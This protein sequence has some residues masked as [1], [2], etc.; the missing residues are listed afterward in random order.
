MGQQWSVLDALVV[1]IVLFFVVRGVRVGFVRQIASIAAL[2]FAFVVAGRFYGE[3]SSF[4]LPFISNP[5]IGFFLIYAALFIITFSAVILLGF[6]L[7]SIITIS[8]LGWFDRLLGGGLGLSKAILVSCLFFMGLTLFV[9]DTS[10]FFRRSFF[11]PY[12]ANASRI[13]LTLVKDKQLRKNLFPHPPVVLT[14]IDSSI[15]FSKNVERHTQQ[16]P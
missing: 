13:I 10:P 2:I 16:I 8:L 3:S 14:F 9:T 5:Q 11:Y 7:K 1:V 4:V 12:L 15:E 6:L